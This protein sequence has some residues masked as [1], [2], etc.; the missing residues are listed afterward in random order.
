MLLGEQVLSEESS[1]GGL[2]AVPTLTEVSR[3][4][5]D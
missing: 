5:H 3:L 4:F 2:E 1:D